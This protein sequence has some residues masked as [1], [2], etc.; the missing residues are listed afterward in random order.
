METELLRGCVLSFPLMMES[1]E[2][3][4]PDKN[5]TLLNDLC[6]MF[7]GMTLTEFVAAT[8]ARAMHS[9]SH[10]HGGR[11]SRQKRR[12]INKATLD[13]YVQHSSSYINL[14]KAKTLEEKNTLYIKACHSRWVIFLCFIPKRPLKIHVPKKIS[15]EKLRRS[16]GDWWGSW[17]AS[18]CQAHH[19]DCCTLCLHHPQFCT[20]ISSTR[21]S[22]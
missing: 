16:S 21:F 8:T 13:A 17:R 12:A 3:P 10:S 7:I 22:V 11:L 1:A 6:T 14:C 4:L 15:F 19:T 18:H 9:Q 5:T 20:Y 2:E